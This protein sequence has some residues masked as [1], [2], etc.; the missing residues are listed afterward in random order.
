MWD[1]RCP[2]CGSGIKWWPDDLFLPNCDKKECMHCKEV[3][4][5]TNPAVCSGINGLIFSGIMVTLTFVG[6]SWQ[7]V[8]G[9]TAGFV[10]WFI[11]PFIVQLLGRWHGRT[12]RAKDRGKVRIWAIVGTVSGLVF[13]IAVALTVI[14]FGFIYREI[15][16][17]LSTTEGVLGSE[18]I[19]D[20]T[21]KARFW[22]P[23]GIGAALA[24]FA[25]A[26]IA[27][28][29]RLQLRNEQQQEGTK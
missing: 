11:H 24:A 8:R 16:M 22:L 21:G 1:M 7:W 17:N 29:R 28:M 23:I 9:L 4:E 18:A 13:G 19:E 10:C 26:K 12:Y 25:L 5:L 15:L 20:L 6:F 14:G 2:K 27:S 3:F